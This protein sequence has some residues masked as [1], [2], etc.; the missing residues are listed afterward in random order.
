MATIAK[1]QIHTQVAEAQKSLVAEATGHWT[2]SAKMPAN[3]RVSEPQISPGSDRPLG[4]IAEL[5][6]NA[7]V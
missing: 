4:K 5:G 3:E 6:T 7:E 1:L 2:R